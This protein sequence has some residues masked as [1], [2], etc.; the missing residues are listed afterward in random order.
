MKIVQIVRNFSNGGAERF[1]V[2][3]SNQLHKNGHEVIIIRFHAEAALNF[4]EGEV[5]PGVKVLTFDRKGKLDLSLMR[6][7]RRFL[8]AEKPDVVHTHMNDAFLYNL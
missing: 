1:V 5:L 8:A 3:L 7:L 6:R 2:D 4:F